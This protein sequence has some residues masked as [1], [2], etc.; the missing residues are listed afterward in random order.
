[1]IL[2]LILLFSSNVDSVPGT[3]TKLYDGVIHPVDDITTQMEELKLQNLPRHVGM[4]DDKSD[5]ATL[6][7]FRFLAKLVSL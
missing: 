1:M 5:D 7:A 3:V 6:K 4:R 2:I